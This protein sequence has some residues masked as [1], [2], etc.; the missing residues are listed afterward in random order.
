[1]K[2]VIHIK[3]GVRNIVIDADGEVILGFG[4]SSIH[5]ARL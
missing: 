3:A 4:L 2:E 5:P 1:M